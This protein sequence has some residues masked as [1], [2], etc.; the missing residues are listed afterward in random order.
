MKLYGLTLLFLATTSTA[1]ADT[2]NLGDWKYTME[3]EK[4]Q[5]LMAKKK[6]AVRFVMIECNENSSEVNLS[7]EFEKAPNNVNEGQMSMIDLNMVFSDSSYQRVPLASVST[8][9]T[10]GQ[11]MTPIDVEV[12]V[13]MASN[14]EVNFSWKYR[15]DET[16]YQDVSLHNA[17]GE[18]IKM[19]KACL[20]D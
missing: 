13:N 5:V 14:A 15:G 8:A 12:L 9:P 4:H 1:T 17:R 16:I 6:S 19:M 3:S 10:F 2:Y 18:I 20:P 7:V 11:S